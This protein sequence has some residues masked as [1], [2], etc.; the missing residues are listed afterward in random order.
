MMAFGTDAYGVA[1]FAASPSLLGE[2]STSYLG[3]WV[4]DAVTLGAAV[5]AFGCCLA[6]M[7]GASRLLFWS[8][9]IG[10]LILLVL[11]YTLY[12]NVIPYP[13]EGPPQWFPIV[14]SGWLLIALIAVV[15]APQLARRIGADLTAAEGIAR[16]ENG[17]METSMPRPD[18]GVCG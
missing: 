17:P 18:S 13:T 6:C 4:G 3:S 7:V 16:E 1:A 5:S 9:T 10:T 14:A 2:I 8:G 15:A 12:R 11:G